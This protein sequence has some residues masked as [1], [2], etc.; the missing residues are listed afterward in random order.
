MS[1]IPWR[2]HI[3][4]APEGQ[5][6]T[7]GFEHPGHERHEVVAKMERVEAKS[8][9]LVHLESSIRQVRKIRTETGTIYQF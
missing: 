8:P 1:E 5:P 2:R 4:A 3:S 6:H 7:H 9:V